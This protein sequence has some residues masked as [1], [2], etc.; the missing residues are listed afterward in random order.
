MGVQWGF[1]EP[2]N[3]LGMAFLK[4]CS[5]FIT[6]R[7]KLDG[8]KQSLLHAISGQARLAILRICVVSGANGL[9]P[10][11]LASKQSYDPRCLKKGFQT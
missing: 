6:C 1:S 2:P 5:A 10:P 4:L 3:F 11:S 8:G 9:S 7:Y